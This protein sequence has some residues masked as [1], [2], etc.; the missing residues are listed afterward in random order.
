MKGKPGGL[1]L[2]VYNPTGTIEI[3]QRY[4][5]RLADLRGK[6]ICELSNLTWEDQRT[7]PIIRELLQ[8]QFPDVKIIPYTEF[9]GI[10]GFDAEAL[11]KALKEKGCEGAIVGNAA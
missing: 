2:E 10:F 6:T 11:S 1:S 3:T 4:A 9:P 5:P 8:K 7:F